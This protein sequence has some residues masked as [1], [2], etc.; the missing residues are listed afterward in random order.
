VE[1]ANERGLPPARSIPARSQI[2]T[3]HFFL[4]GAFL[5]AAFFLAGAFLAAA[6]FLAGAFFFAAMGVSLS[7]LVWY[8]SALL[9]S[10]IGSESSAH[11][12]LYRIVSDQFSGG[13]DSIR[14][15]F[16]RYYK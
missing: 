2:G 16:S 8:C 9:S 11:I 3:N 12:D 1:N 15:D 14:L 4:A 10:R 7:G 6:F 5:A 13:T